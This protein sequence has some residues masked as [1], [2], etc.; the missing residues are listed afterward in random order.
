MSDSHYQSSS[1][2]LAPAPG[3]LLK[4]NASSDE[5][6]PAR[7]H[8]TTAC[9]ACKR[10]KLKCRGDPPCQ[11]CVSHGIKCE[12]DAM[13][14]MR[15]KNAMDRKLAKLEKVADTL[16]RLVNALRDSESRRVSQLLNLIRSNASF[17]ELQLFLEQQFSRYEL[18]STPELRDIQSQLSQ[19]TDVA[20]L[21]WRYLRVD[22]LADDPVYKVPAKPWTAVTDDSELVSHLVS[23]WLTWTYPWFNWLDADCLIKHMQE[24]KLDSRFCSPFLV[25]AILAEACYYSDY[26]E[27]FTVPGDML[28]RG[29][30]F[31]DEARRLFEAGE[32]EGDSPSLPTIQGLMILFVRTSLM[33]KDRMGWVYLDLAARGAQEYAASHPPHAMEDAEERRAIDRTL[34][35]IFSMASTASVS[36]MK[37]FDIHPPRQSPVT[38]IIH[39]RHKDDVWQPYPRSTDAG[40]PSHI[41]CVFNRWCAIACIT[42]E[43]SRAFYQEEDRIP[44]AEMLPFV[45]DIYQKLQDWYA[46]MPE[47]LLI[48]NVTV[49]HALSLHLFYHT[50]VMQIF[51]LLKANN[52]HL[53]PETIQSARNICIENALRIAHLIGIHRDKWGIGRMAPSTIQWLSI[54]MFTL[55]EALDSP[56]HRN[57]AAFIELC[58]VA[59]AIAR[60]FP[61]AKGIL[62]MIQLSANQMQVVLPAETDALFTDFE[63]RSWEGKD[64]HT[65]STFYPNFVTAVRQ[66]A[67]RE[68]DVSMDRFL[69]KWDSLAISDSKEETPTE[70]TDGTDGS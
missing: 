41:S 57:R 7:K 51:G 44:R 55:L 53:D 12:V 20:P 3:R 58:I 28:T 23:L 40:V 43:I 63:T 49:P 30:Q 70:K 5:L 4:R 15:R 54:G 25:N 37:H 68:G 47:C 33:G 21:G 22:R 50:T 42:V 46:D 10:K 18:E 36:L 59:R 2:P 11:H 6:V 56:D 35:G 17:D 60:R 14:D 64:R 65:F 45:N 62:R 8:K 16:T 9:K 29:D 31:F 66:G 19:T 61:L 34:W 48:E 39:Q 27:V 38:R 13:S 67:A 1:R 69:E 26:E 24:G 52:E 32:D